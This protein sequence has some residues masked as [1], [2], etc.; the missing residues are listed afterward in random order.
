MGAEQPVAWAPWAASARAASNMDLAA[1]ADGAIV[2]YYASLVVP[3]AVRERLAG[4][5]DSD[6]K[7]RARAF[8]DP[9]HGDRFAVSR[10]T[11][12]VLLARFLEVSAETVRFASGPNGKPN[13]DGPKTTPPLQFNVSHSGDR[14]AVAVSMQGPVGIDMVR[15]RPV[16]DAGDLAARILTAKELATFEALPESQRERTF[17]VTWVRKEACLKAVGAGFSM[18]APGFEVMGLSNSAG[19]APVAGFGAEWHLHTLDPWDGYVGAVVAPGPDRQVAPFDVTWNP[20]GE[21]S[22]A[23]RARSSARSE[24]V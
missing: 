16:P 15:L 5:L 6:E 24:P 8:L 21:G 23:P 4:L 7:A 2:V 11:V 14:L 3:D 20:L 17:L 22:V 19:S 10:G 9:R 18:P 13:L 12:R 1:F